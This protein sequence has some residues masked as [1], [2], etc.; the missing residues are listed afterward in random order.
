MARFLHMVMKSEIELQDEIISVLR[1]RKFAFTTQLQ[2]CSSSNVVYTEG[3]HGNLRL[4]R[5]KLNL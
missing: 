5:L 2:L 4:L 1:A 3:K